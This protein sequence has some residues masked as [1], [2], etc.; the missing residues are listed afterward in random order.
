MNSSFAEFG[1]FK[2]GIRVLTNSKF[3]EFEDFEE[4]MFGRKQL[5]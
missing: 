2:L 3:A 4:S 1:D 5:F